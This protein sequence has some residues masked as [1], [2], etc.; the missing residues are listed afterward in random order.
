MKPAM[1]LVQI[2]TWALLLLVEFSSAALAAVPDTIAERVKPCL[3]CHGPEDRAGKDAYYPRVAGK[4]ATYLYRQLLNFRDGRRYYRPMAVLLENLSDDYL[5]EMA[6]YLATVAPVYARPQTGSVRP[7]DFEQGR[8]LVVQGDAAREVPACTACHGKQLTGVAPAI[9]GL[10]GLPRAYIDAQFGAWRQGLRRGPAP[11]CMAEVAR[12]L[13][14]EE[15]N[16]VAAWLAAQPVPPDAH[17]A[18]AP[19]GPLPLR[20]GSV[21]GAENKP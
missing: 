3:V 2:G 4:P 10:L 14:G 13:G 20:C 6:D 17:T 7:E 5:R 11:D 12:R 19:D 21:P 9:P 18:A 16:A 8:R 1:K 15:A